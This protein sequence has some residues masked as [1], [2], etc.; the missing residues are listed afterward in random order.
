M[1]KSEEPDLPQL[2]GQL[3]ILC[4]KDEEELTTLMSASPQEYISLLERIN[5]FLFTACGNANKVGELITTLKLQR[6][7]P[8]CLVRHVKHEY[9]ADIRLIDR[10][11]GKEKNVE[12]KASFTKKQNAY[13]SNWSFSVS[14]L[15]VRHRGIYPATLP[16]E[17]EVDLF[18]RGC[19]QK[20]SGYVV[21]HASCRS[22]ELN[23]Y[24]MDG[25]FVALV[26][27]KKALPA[28]DS[29]KTVINLGGRRCD[30]CEEYHRI[31]NLQ[32]YEA[33]FKDIRK[34]RGNK[35]V[36]SFD[37]FSTAEWKDILHTPSACITK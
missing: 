15:V 36:F 12:N 22:G 10:E 11:T 21:L 18:V 27:C 20:M 28:I 32:S 31:V 14:R 34:E 16:T 7:M 33:L 4:E 19:Y 37:C 2:I 1:L 30:K 29:K 8:E 23:T 3:G 26:L 9:G 13:R 6:S 5:V 35:P 17:E 24:L 25:N